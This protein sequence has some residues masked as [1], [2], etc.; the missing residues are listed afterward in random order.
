MNL[1]RSATKESVVLR[2]VPLGQ[3]VTVLGD[4]DGVWWRVRY[5]GVTGYMM[6]EFLRIV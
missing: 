1:R 5:E 2:R 6:Q 3:Q 4:V